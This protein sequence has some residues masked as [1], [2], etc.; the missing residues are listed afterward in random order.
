[1]TETTTIDDAS[2]AMRRWNA[3]PGQFTKIMVRL[4]NKALT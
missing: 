1:M 3:N 2:E 4:H